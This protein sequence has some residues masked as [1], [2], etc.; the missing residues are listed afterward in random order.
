ME[1]NEDIYPLEHFDF[2]IKNLNAALEEACDKIGYSGG[3]VNCI[4]LKK[5]LIS[6]SSKSTFNRKAIL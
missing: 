2:N 6:R 4:S 1:Y 5:T 3:A